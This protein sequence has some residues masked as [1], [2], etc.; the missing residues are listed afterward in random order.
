MVE[1]MVEAMVEDMVEDMDIVN[2]SLDMCKK[3]SLRTWLI[4]LRTSLRTRKLFTVHLKYV[5][6]MLEY[7][8]EAPVLGLWRRRR[9]I[10]RFALASDR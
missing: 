5:E 2:I 8:V 9:E 7:M 10:C 4:W 1:A 6:N 3:R